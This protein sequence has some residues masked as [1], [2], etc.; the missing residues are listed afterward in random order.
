MQ[1][2]A[3]KTAILAASLVAGVSGYLLLKST[4]Q[5]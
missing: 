1:L 4:A 5:K 2:D 3:A